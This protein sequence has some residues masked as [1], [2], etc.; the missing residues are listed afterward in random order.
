M[1]AILQSLDQFELRYESTQ[2]VYPLHMSGI[3][4]I[5]SSVLQHRVLTTPESVCSLFF[6]KINKSENHRNLSLIDKMS[7]CHASLLKAG[8]AIT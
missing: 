8:N 1:S 7:L 2:K 3:C 5:L 6:K 4:M